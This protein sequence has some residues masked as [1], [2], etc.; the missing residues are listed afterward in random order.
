M[1]PARVLLV[2]RPR[3]K[4]EKYGSMKLLVATGN[5]HKVRE[6]AQI[7][8]H[9]NIDVISP[10]AIGGLPEVE[11]D[12]ETFCANAVKKAVVCADAAGVPVFADDSGLEVAALDGRPGVRSARYAGEQAA[13]ADNV[14]K[15]LQE[16][17]GAEDRRACFVCV[18]AVAVPAGLIGTAHGRVCGTITDAPRGDSG[19]GYDPVFVPDGYKTTFAELESE[20]K[21]RMS[22]RANA[23]RT[24]CRQGLFARVRDV[25]DRSGR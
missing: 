9:E 5:R 19:F 23:L 16:L 3:R 8:A 11:E 12:G 2:L 24:A 4:R 13:D 25:C 6:V 10:E 17:Q 7:L 18:I 20:S 1:R 14:R 21:N 15:L 22:H